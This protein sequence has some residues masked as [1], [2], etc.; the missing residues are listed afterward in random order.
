VVPRQRGLA[1]LA[2]AEYPDDR[3]AAEILPN[4]PQ[5]DRSFHAV[6]MKIQIMNLFF[7]E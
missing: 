5:E 3:M 6:S 2:G 7:H 4:Q 1:A